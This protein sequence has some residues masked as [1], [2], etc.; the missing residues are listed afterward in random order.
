[1]FQTRRRQLLL[2]PLQLL[3]PPPLLPEAEDTQD[4]MHAAL[5]Y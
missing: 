3:L 1:L 2:P 5:S 4:L